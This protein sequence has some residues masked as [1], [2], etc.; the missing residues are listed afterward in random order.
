LQKIGE[1]RSTTIFKDFAH[2]PS[3]LRAT[4]QALKK[5]FPERDLVACIELHTFS[6]LSKSF[7][8]FY[9]GSLNDADLPMV[10]FS[11][12]ALA[13]KKL[14]PIRS[15]DVRKAFGHSGLNVITKPEKLEQELLK[16]NWKDKNLLMMSSGSFDGLDLDK[17]AARILDSTG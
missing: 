15:E 5:Q 16:I 12:H 8:P 11:P 4:T 13:L 14:P 3:K 17:L 1:N 6:S 10:Y 7:L 2:A 9:K